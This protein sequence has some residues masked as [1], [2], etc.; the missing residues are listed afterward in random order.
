MVQNRAVDDALLNVTEAIRDAADAAIPKTSNSTR[1]LCKPWWNSSCQQAKKEQ[2]RAWGIFRRYPT[3]ENLIA[4][5]RAKALARRIRRQCQRESWI[6]YVSSITSSTSS[7]QLWRK[8][9]AANGLYREFKIP[10]LETSTA[11]YSSPFEVANLICQTFASVSSS[12][13][14]SPA[15]QVTK[16][17]LER[18]PINFKCRQL[19]P[20]NCDFDMFELKRALSSANNTSPGPDG[21][22]Y[23]LL[24]HLNE[25]SLVSL[26][27]LFNRIWK[28]Q[29]YPTQWKEVIVIPILKPGKDQKNPLSY[30]P[31]ALTSCLCNTLERMVNAC[32]VYQLE[33]NKCIPLFQ[34]G[35]P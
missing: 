7:Q 21:I 28:Q 22:S 14:Y 13:S 4:F 33:K 35:F 31:I 16:N 29:L 18:T 20:Y 30:R 32:L 10:I 34:R 12:D 25:D 8:V 2:R 26:L 19:L 11:L 24:R 3:T 27:Y 1:K 17:R 23:E 6:K 9:K 5:K 15:F